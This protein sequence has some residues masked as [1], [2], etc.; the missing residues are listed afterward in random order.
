[1]NETTE[2]KQNNSMV[3][4][5]TVGFDQDKNTYCV[6]L[7]KGSNVAETAFAMAVVIKCLTKDGV[8]KKHK[9]IIDLVEKYLTD[10][11]YEEVKDNKE[12]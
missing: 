6:S 1:M 9:D 12:E 8:I 10:P 11:Q 3:T 2:N 5:M 7:G 4:L